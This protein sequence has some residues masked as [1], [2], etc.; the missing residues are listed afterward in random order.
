MGDT[1]GP[2]E[3]GASGTDDEPESS[4]ADSAAAGFASRRCGD[5]GTAAPTLGDGHRAT[6]I[7]T[8]GAAR[9]NAASDSTEAAVDLDVIVEGAGPSAGEGSVATATTGTAANGTG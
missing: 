2:S 3:M 9:T 6:A 1:D 7:A 4:P 8:R 5:V